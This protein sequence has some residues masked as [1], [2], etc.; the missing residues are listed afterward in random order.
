MEDDI[1]DEYQSIQGQISEDGN[2]SVSGTGHRGTI[3]WKLSFRGNASS[4]TTMHLTGVQNNRAGCVIDLSNTK[5]A[6]NSRAGLEVAAQTAAASNIDTILL[7]GLPKGEI[8]DLW[9]TWLPSM[10]LQEKQFCEIINKFANDLVKANNDRNGLEYA[11]VHRRRAQDLSN[12]LPAGSIQNWIVHYL[13]VRLAPDGSAAVTFQ[14][15]CKGLIGSNSCKGEPNERRGLIPQDSPFYRELE[16]FESGSFVILSGT[17]P[18]IEEREGPPQAFLNP[19]P[20]TG[21]VGNK[22]EE[23]LFVLE[24]ES[25]FKLV[26]PGH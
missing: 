6:P 12:L 10:P 3:F 1:D 22:T 24:P 9:K 26:Q 15:P 19:P 7:K 16:K 23:E 17:L 14:P 21:C 4:A 25:I 8:A 13:E 5:P 11:V 18:A 2:I 20:G